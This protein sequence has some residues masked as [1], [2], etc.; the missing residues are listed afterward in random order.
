MV[1]EDP[2]GQGVERADAPRRQAEADAEAAGAGDA[3][4]QAGEGARAEADGEQVDAL[5]AAGRDGRPLDLLQ[6]PGRVQRPSGG[7][8]PQLRLVQDL[9]VAPGAGDGVDRR[10]VEADDYQGFATPSP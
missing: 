8:K 3:D 6:Q 9:S 1:L 7:G 10:G 2:R 4:T 5:P